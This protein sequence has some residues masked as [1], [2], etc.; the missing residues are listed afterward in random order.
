LESAQG[1]PSVLRTFGR[2]PV[3]VL[4]KSEMFEFRTLLFGFV[5]L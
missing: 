3:R 4:K 1:T 5:V 2:T